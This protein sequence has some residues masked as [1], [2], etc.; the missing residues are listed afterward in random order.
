MTN[1]NLT[2]IKEMGTVVTGK[3]SSTTVSDYYGGDYLFISPSGL[4]GSYMGN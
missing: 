3:T 2:K 4:H 1:Y